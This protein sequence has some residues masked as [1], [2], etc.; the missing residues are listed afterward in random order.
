[1]NDDEK[2][3]VKLGVKKGVVKKGF[4]RLKKGVVKKRCCNKV[5]EYRKL[6]SI[7]H[8]HTSATSCFSR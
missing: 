8:V 1:M 2:L 6:W 4:L 3:G 5:V 7:E